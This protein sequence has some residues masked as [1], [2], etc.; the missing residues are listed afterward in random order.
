M[1]KT[2]SPI[3]LPTQQPNLIE[4]RKHQFVCTKSNNH[5]A[6]LM[7]GSARHCRTRLSVYLRAPWQ[8]LPIRSTFNRSPSRHIL[9]AYQ[10][11]GRQ[12]H[13]VTIRT[14]QRFHAH[15][16]RLRHELERA[17]FPATQTSR[18]FRLKIRPLS[19]R[20]ALALEQ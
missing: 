1:G 13:P 14:Y 11:R 16:H 17:L 10:L 5:P 6:H 20:P 19:Q 12:L 8:H 18:P 2:K 15:C 3:I 9:Y 7:P 4:K